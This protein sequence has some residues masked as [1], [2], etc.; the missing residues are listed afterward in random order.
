[1]AL[2]KTCNRS[3]AARMGK[4][5][6]EGYSVKEIA[7]ATRVLPAVVERV[8]ANTNVPAARGPAGAGIDVED[9]GLSK[10]DQRTIAAD[11]AIPPSAVVPAETPVAPAAVAAPVAP[12]V[13]NRSPQ[14][15]AAD[16]RKANKAAAAAAPVAPAVAAPA[17]APAGDPAFSE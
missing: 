16:T 11:P 1:M 12:A 17:G 7:A 4:L 9:T 8:L 5:H 15:K 13:D 10:A 14:Q 6:N 3:D 2:K